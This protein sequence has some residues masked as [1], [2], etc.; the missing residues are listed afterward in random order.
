[1]M[2]AKG[3]HFA[4]AFGPLFDIK[5]KNTAPGI[6]GPSIGVGFHYEFVK[7]LTLSTGVSA[8][9][10]FGEYNNEKKY[11]QSFLTMVPYRIHGRILLHRP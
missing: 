2:T 11:F 10:Q 3:T 6:S 7:G 9:V 1:M 5:K 8:L 4:S